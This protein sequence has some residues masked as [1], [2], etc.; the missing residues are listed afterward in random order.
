[1]IANPKRGQR[2]QIWYR[3]DRATFM[4]WHASEGV[5]LIVSRGK[6]RNHG[7]LVG[8]TVIVVP[9]GNLRKVEVSP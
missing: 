2:V 8:T 6:P 7:V 4:P 9:C 5:V 1:V 3:A